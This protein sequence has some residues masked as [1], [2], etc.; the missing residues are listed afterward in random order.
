MR[1]YFP[2]RSFHC[3]VYPLAEV[4]ALAQQAIRPLVVF[5]VVVHGMPTGASKLVG[6]GNNQRDLLVGFA[7]GVLVVIQ[8]AA[9]AW[10]S[11]ISTAPVG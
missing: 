9:V 8:S 11:V 1:V 5:L 7:H 2:R 10:V 3:S 6:R 4:L